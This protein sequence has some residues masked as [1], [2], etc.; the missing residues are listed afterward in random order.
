MV[1][2]YQW[3]TEILTKKFQDG[4]IS[5]SEIERMDFRTQVKN[6]ETAG[7]IVRQS[8][9]TLQKSGEMKLREMAFPEVDETLGSVTSRISQPPPILIQ[10]K[11][12]A[13]VALD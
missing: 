3:R 6:I 12:R 4:G 2:E 11:R 8:M 13:T 10:T 5:R 9:T 1:D 7:P